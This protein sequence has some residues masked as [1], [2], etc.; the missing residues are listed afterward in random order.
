MLQQFC[1]DCRLYRKS[2]LTMLLSLV[3][4]FLLGIGMVILIMTMEEDPG[5]W[6]CMGTLLT[7]IALLVMQLLFA[8]FSYAQEFSLALSFGRTRTAFMGAYA[9]RIV[10]QLILGWF[11]ILGLH[12]IELALYPRLF[13]QYGNEIYFGFLTNWRVMVPVLLGLPILSMFIGSLYGHFGKK[14]L[15]LFYIV[16]LFCCFV[17]PRMFD[18]EPGDGVLDQ[19]AVSLMTVFVT[20]PP[21]VWLTFGLAAAAAMVTGILLLGRRQMVR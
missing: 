3:G 15:W 5:A 19:M 8:A 16:W 11:L 6:F 13:P 9:L 4:I 7:C 18:R 20:V 10:L 14:G 1:L 17:L 2:S 12:R 21:S